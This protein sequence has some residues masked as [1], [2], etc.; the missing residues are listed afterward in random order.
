MTR[1]GFIGLGNMGLP[2]AT[3]LRDAKH[4]LVVQDVRWE[5]ALQFAGAEA[6]AARTPRDLADGVDVILM[7]LPTPAAVR[8][9]VE[10]EQ[11][12]A[13]GGRA[14]LVIDLSTTGPSTA[15]DAA[16]VLKQRGIEFVDAPV[17]GGV[18]GAAKGTLAIMASGAAADFDRA[19][20]L[21]ETLGRVFL[22]GDKPGQGQ[23]MKLLNN[24]LSANAMAATAEVIVLGVKAGLDAR[25]MLDVLNASSGRNTAT[26]DKFPRSVLDRSFNFGF[27]TVL[28]YKDVRLCKEFADEYGVPFTI[29]SAVAKVWENAAQELGDG[30][31][32]RV[33][34]L[35]EKRAGVKVSGNAAPALVAPAKSEA[36]P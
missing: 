15:V 20:P 35:M 28:L 5:H 11:G 8:S 27:R 6:G 17:S 21:L 24:V 19:R 23:A 25:A 4:D 22:V 16:K 13:Q 12:I 34:E 3:R 36:N 29:G 32:T 2:M 7:S 31:F 33:V 9:V 10:G 18:T 14:K 30:D 26:T 1:I